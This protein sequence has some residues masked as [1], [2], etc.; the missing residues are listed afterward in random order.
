MD[1]VLFGLHFFYG[2]SKG[3]PGISGAG[4]ILFSPDRSS[5]LSFGWGLSFMSNNQAESYSLLK[6]LQLA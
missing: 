6:A 4:G 3:N 1:D 2:V 5:E